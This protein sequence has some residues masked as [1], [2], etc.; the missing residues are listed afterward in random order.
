MIEARVRRPTAAPDAGS[1]PKARRLPPQ[2]RKLVLATHVLVAVGWFGVVVGKLILEI[3][4]ATTPDPDIPGAAYLFMEA[5]DRALFPPT[6]LATL[7][8]GIVLSVGTAWGLF[9]HYWIVAKLV[10]TVAVIVTGVVFVGA[11]T[12]Q[13]IATASGSASIPLIY[14]SLAHLVMLGAATVISIYK[15]WGRIR[16]ARRDTA[17]QPARHASP[18][19]ALPRR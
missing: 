10:L 3:T 2:L 19:H 7:L 9:Q 13:A 6:A 14:A 12:R 4:A 18:S 8:T 17:R 5:F 11:W 15:P 16:P 1:A